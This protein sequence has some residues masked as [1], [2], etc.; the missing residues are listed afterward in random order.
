[1]NTDE[2]N[3]VLD[4]SPRSTL[5]RRERCSENKETFCDNKIIQNFSFFMAEGNADPRPRVVIPNVF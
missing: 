5:N 2:D 4:L 1:M 3:T